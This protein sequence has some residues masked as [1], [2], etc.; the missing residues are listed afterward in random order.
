MSW[1][2]LNR[3]MQFSISSVEQFTPN[4][5]FSM[6]PYF[7]DMSTLIVCDMF[8]KFPLEIISRVSI[9]DWG[10]LIISIGKIY[11]IYFSISS[12]L[13]RKD[14]RWWLSYHGDSSILCISIMDSSDGK[15]LRM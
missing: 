3:A 10:L 8:P 7:S 4:C 15:I 9:R 11:E 6:K 13:G 14:E 1:N 12:K 2:S 5:M